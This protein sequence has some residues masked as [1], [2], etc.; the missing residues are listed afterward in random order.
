ME[1]PL[2]PVKN[3]LPLH[4][5]NPRLLL[6]LHSPSPFHLLSCIL[7]EASTPSSYYTRYN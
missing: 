6:W 1:L 5:P 3:N 4:Q 7:E 2:Q